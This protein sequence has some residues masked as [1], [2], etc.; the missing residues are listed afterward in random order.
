MSERMNDDKI[1]NCKRLW[2]VVMRTT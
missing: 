1:Q 2:P